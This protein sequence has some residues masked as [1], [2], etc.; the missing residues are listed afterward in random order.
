MER[1]AREA[2]LNN[3]MTLMGFIGPPHHRSIYFYFSVCSLLCAL[4]GTCVQIN[5]LN[6]QL[7]K[8]AH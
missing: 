8:K 2:C 5:E 7:K 3:L 1:E 6:V 4:H